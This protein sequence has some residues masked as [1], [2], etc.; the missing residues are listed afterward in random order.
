MVAHIPSYADDFDHWGI[1]EFSD[2]EENVFHG[3]I[4]SQ[5][6]YFGLEFKVLSDKVLKQTLALS[7]GYK[8]T[9]LTLETNN[10]LILT[11]T[12][13]VPLYLPGTPEDMTDVIEDEVIFTR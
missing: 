12:Y 11:C 1:F 8:E 5:D 6:D 9:T 2:G 13:H 10:R 3:G 7:T 4:V